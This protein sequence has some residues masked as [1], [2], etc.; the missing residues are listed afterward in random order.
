[1]SGVTNWSKCAEIMP[2]E[3]GHYLCWDEK[4]EMMWI[5]AFNDDGGQDTWGDERSLGWVGVQD[6][7]SLWPTH[8]APRPMAPYGKWL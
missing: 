5:G 7:P 8:W 4:T 1:M 2:D 3:S 6:S